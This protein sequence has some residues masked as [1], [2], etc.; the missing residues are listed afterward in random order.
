MVLIGEKDSPTAGT[1]STAYLVVPTSSVVSISTCRVGAASGLSNVDPFTFVYPSANDSVATCGIAAV[2]GIRVAGPAAGSTLYDVTNVSSFVSKAVGIG[3][4]GAVATFARSTPAAP[5]VLNPRALPLAWGDLK[6]A[7]QGALH[8][9]QLLYLSLICR[10][11]YRYCYCGPPWFQVRSHHLSHLR[12][13]VLPRDPRRRAPSVFTRHPF[14]VRYLITATS[15]PFSN[16]S[17]L[18]LLSLPIVSPTTPPPLCATTQSFSSVSPPPRLW[19][20]SPPPAGP[21]VPSTPLHPSD[22]PLLLP[23]LPLQ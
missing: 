3:G 10:Y 18:A 16:S 17:L 14:S 11:I 5:G 6:S 22:R 21:E 7:L 8:N 13:R 4:S 23:A 20:S 15:S 2:G 19:S 1:D 12:Q 9:P